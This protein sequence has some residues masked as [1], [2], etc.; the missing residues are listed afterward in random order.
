MTYNLK[1]LKHLEVMA[2]IA[3]ATPAPPR[4]IN[5][6]ALLATDEVREIGVDEKILS[7]CAK[8]RQEGFNK[9]ADGLEA[10]F[11]TY[12]S[13]TTHLYR[14][15]DEDGEDLIHAAHPDGDNAICDA[16][17]GLGDVET[18]ISEHKKIIDLV[19]KDPKGK[20]AS[21]VNKLEKRADVVIADIGKKFK[22][23]ADYI[24]QHAMS[25]VPEG[26]TLQPEER[27]FYGIAAMWHKV[28][29][30]IATELNSP[31]SL[32]ERE[33]V[34]LVKNRLANSESDTVKHQ[35][36]A[37]NSLADMDKLIHEVLTRVTD[38]NPNKLASYV[39]ACKSILNKKVEA[40]GVATLVGGPV[41]G[42]GH[43]I[44][45]IW[46]AIKSVFGDVADSAEMLREAVA[47]L[48]K[49]SDVQR[50]AALKQMMQNTTLPN[51]NIAINSSQLV[52][53]L[54]LNTKN[55]L[56]QIIQYKEFYTALQSHLVDLKLEITKDQELFKAQQSASSKTF[57]AVYNVFVMS[58]A[59]KVK[60]AASSLYS[61]L[62]DA[63]L[64]L[65][66]AETD[67][68]TVAPTGPTQTNTLLKPLFNAT[69]SAA[70]T[71]IAELN[72]LTPKVQSKQIPDA[73]KQ[74]GLNFI[75]EQ[76]KDVQQHGNDP[77]K[78]QALTKETKDFIVDWKL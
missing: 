70:E 63:L 25:N 11:L 30:V 57:N 13:A 4:E 75:Q 59:N 26:E 58:N 62:A 78:L 14:T 51:L 36:E 3:N 53:D 38:K 43:A 23:M 67:S 2:D 55:K 77:T 17:N 10:K 9:Q 24:Q 20:L 1:D 71:L 8:L 44:Y 40:Q 29:S 16:E 66:Q 31:A 47:E 73:K 6:K 19:T 21:Q 46:K 74:Q 48:L 5:I 42:A 45:N 28:A 33:A 49:D 60:G 35:A 7:L 27:N 34:Q 72:S 32:P 68:Q 56:P 65:G 18:I 37:V 64:L 76:I 61:V 41:A 22:Y 69:S 39:N 50:F 52:K 12:K 54:E 15:H